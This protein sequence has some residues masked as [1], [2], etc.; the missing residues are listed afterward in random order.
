MLLFKKF[1]TGTIIFCFSKDNEHNDKIIDKNVSVII[2]S[3][4]VE[5]SII[6]LGSTDETK[7]L[8]FSKL[9][10]NKKG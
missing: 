9:E 10:K 3:L 8:K 5:M 7:F 6:S 2:L 4:W 1:N